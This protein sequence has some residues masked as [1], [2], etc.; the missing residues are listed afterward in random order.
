MKLEINKTKNGNS[1]LVIDKKENNI[2]AVLLEKNQK[3]PVL[4]EN[5][6]ILVL[7][8]AVGLRIQVQG[9]LF[10]FVKVERE[11]VGTEEQWENNSIQQLQRKGLFNFYGEFIPSNR[12]TDRLDVIYKMEGV[13][14]CNNPLDS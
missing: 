11:Y 4:K 7:A 6:H 5:E 10:T 1:C 12:Y 3:N 8:P 13:E 14:L 2:E 9:Q